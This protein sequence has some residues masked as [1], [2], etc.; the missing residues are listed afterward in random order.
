[1]IHSQSN[2]QKDTS[3]SERRAV[4]EFLPALSEKQ[5]FR[6]E[7]GFIYTKVLFNFLSGN[8]KGAKYDI[9]FC[10]KHGHWILKMKTTIMLLLMTRKKNGAYK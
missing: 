10:I 4:A 8:Y 6:L 3:P 5:K 1:L 2:S 7:A 9:I